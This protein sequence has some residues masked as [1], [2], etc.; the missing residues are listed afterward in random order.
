MENA[1]L[2]TNTCHTGRG[3]LLVPAI[4]Y[5][6]IGLLS[7]GTYRVIGKLRFLEIF[8]QRMRCSIATDT[9]CT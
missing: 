8:E 2:I 5:K 1:E 3:K 6:V 4:S 9:T 7:G